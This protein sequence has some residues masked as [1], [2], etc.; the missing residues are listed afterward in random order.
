MMSDRSPGKS[1]IARIKYNFYYNEGACP[2]ASLEKML[3]P[4][5]TIDEGDCEFVIG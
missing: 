1:R 2:G 3:T 4:T 5:L